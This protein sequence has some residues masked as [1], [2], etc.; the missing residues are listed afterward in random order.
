MKVWAVAFVG[1]SL[2]DWAT[3][4]LVLGRGGREGNPVMG[5]VVGT[6]YFFWV[7]LLLP[8]ALSLWLWRRRAHPR[9]RAL[10]VFG[11]LLTAGAA[12]VNLATAVFG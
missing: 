8:I 2:A 9:A 6:P 7:K 12:G 11:T 4:E 1:A 3:T 5:L 10:L